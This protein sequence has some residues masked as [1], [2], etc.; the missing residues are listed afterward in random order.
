M[1]KEIGL[2]VHIPFC[3][4]KCAYC[5]F[6]SFA[7]REQDEAA[8]VDAVLREAEKRSCIDA[9]VAT[10]YIGGGTP[11]LLPPELMER[12]LS[13]IRSCFDF[14][15]DAEC[16]CE[17]NPGTVTPAFLDTLERNG[18]NRLSFGAQAAQPHLLSLLG[19]IHSWEQ[20]EESVRMA[21]QAG[22]DNI[23]LDL[24]LGLPNQTLSNVRETLEKALALEPTHLSC[25]GLIVEEGT[26]MRRMVES[27]AWTLPDEDT[28]R[29]M[30]EL[31][32][33][34]LA[35]HGFEQYEISNF[36]RPDFAC[37]HN[38]D[39]WKRKEY[40]GLGSAA[41]GFLGNVRYQNPPDLTDYLNGKPAEETV[42]S[43]E[44]ARF[45]S[46][47]LGLRMTEGVSD[48]A[49][50]KM[51]GISIHDVFGKQL[52]KPIRLGLVEWHNG[53]LRLTRKGMDVQNSVLVEL[54]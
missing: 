51:H 22:F 2:Y 6:A 17:C 24:M 28:E 37:R 14:L 9:A 48:A 52:E 26:K 10:L 21:R 23:N 29:D 25:Y 54:L 34:T 19:R 38:A 13:G 20:A 46:M 43:P 33:E 4:R 5:D 36:A 16:S 50:R 12:L 1:K 49:F 7:G 3:V 40:I 8:Y 15:S 11:S 35:Q 47:M 32:R 30:Y 18:V 27:G 42:I 41:C 31:C 44:E 53:F 39:C 45:E